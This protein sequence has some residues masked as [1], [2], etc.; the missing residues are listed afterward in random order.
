[1]G[2]K[3]RRSEAPKDGH[4]Y[5]DRRFDGEIS[6]DCP[7]T[8]ENETSTSDLPKKLPFASYFL[9]WDVCRIVENGNFQM[10]KAPKWNFSRNVN[11]SNV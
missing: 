3:I 8:A 1:M 2:G 5:N 11:F 7:E 9:L 6:L 4:F 10:Y